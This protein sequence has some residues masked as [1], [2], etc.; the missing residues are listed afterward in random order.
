MNLEVTHTNATGVTQ[1]R[2]YK[3]T[4]ARFIKH[5]VSAGAGF[6]PSAALLARG[7][8]AV[9]WYW[10]FIE[11]VALGSSSFGEP[12]LILRDPTL[13]AH[14]SNLA[15]RAFADLLS[16]T[17]TGSWVT[18]SYEGVL[19]QEGLSVVG[20][21]PDLLALSLSSVV[22]IEA[23]GYTKRSVSVNEMLA[24]KNQARRGPL[25][26]HACAASVAY[27]LYRDAKVNYLDPED[28]MPVPRPR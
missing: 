15:G 21:R 20:P 5:F 2:S 26:R 27:S 3:I 4:L 9:A 19:H 28:E 11:P 6:T 8:G 22:A 23:K 24:H 1:H 10:D 25:P 12:I 14:F 16:R 18:F 7:M 17:I 13:K